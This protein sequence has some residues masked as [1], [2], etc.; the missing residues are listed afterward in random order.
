MTAL[1]TRQNWLP[2]ALILLAAVSTRIATWGNP[3]A[4]M[5]DQFY[6]LVGRSWTQG[7]WP[8]I[9]IWDR[10]PIG[11]FAIYAGI[12]AISPSILAVQIAATAFAAA[13]ALL[14]RRAATLIASGT[15]ATMAAIVYL[16]FLPVFGGQTGQSPVFYNLF[17]A[18]AGTILLRSAAEPEHLLRR[19]LWSMALC[20]IALVIKQTSVA[21][22]CFFGL[23]WLWLMQR[24]GMTPPRLAAVAC[25]M[26]VIALIPTVLGFALFAGKGQAALADYAYA[27]YGSIFAKGA[28]TGTAHLGGLA[29]LLLYGLPLLIAVFLARAQEPAGEAQQL[30]RRLLAGWIAAA[31]VGYAMIPNFFPHYALPLLV[32]L[33]ILSAVAFDRPIG[34]LLFAAMAIA[35]LTTGKLTNFGYN[36]A[37]AASFE[38]VAATVQKARHGGCIHVIN[39]PPALYAVVPACHLTRYAFPYHLTLATEGTAVGIRQDVEMARI[40]GLRP[41]VIVTQDDER[42]RQKSAVLAVTDATLARD[43]RQVMAL[44]DEPDPALRSLRVWQRKDL[45]PPT[46]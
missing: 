28:T 8:I 40:L 29:Y 26:I 12:A 20:G 1:R 14:I 2:V 6:W 11:L 27:A 7:Q 45:S 3:V 43:Y 42:D 10:K 31:L 34:K 17:V 41:A 37:T 21:E 18:A 46:R 16:L 32:P 44:P 5:D 15:S 9:D 13:T 25:A 19:A 30:T 39:G 35:S 23:A 36:R 33:S 38:R 24:G 4:D 22:G